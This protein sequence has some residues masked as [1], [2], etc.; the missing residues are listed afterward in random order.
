MTTSSRWI[1]IVAA[2][3]LIISPLAFGQTV[4]EN[5]RSQSHFGPI[6]L[7]AGNF[8]SLRQ[9]FKQLNEDAK[10]TED[11]EQQAKKIADLLKDSKNPQS[12]E[13]MKELAKDPIF[14]DQRFQ[15]WLQ[16]E[17]N[18]HKGEIPPEQF[19]KLDETVK[20][21]GGSSA[22]PTGGPSD[23]E[24]QNRN[25]DDDFEKHLA[26]RKANGGQDAGQPFMGPRPGTPPSSSSDQPNPEESVRRW[27]VDNF[28]PNKGPL[29][30]SPAFQ[31]ALRELRRAPLNLEPPA[32]DQAGWAGKFARWSEDVTKGL[33]KSEFLP[34]FEGSSLKKWRLPSMKSLPKIQSP[35][36]APSFGP[37]PNVALPSATT[38]SRA[39]QVLWIALIAAAGI[40]VWKLLGGNIPGVGRLR[41]A[42]WRLGPWPVSPEA[43]ASRQDV[44]RAFE[45]LSLLKL[46]PS[47]KSRNHLELAAELGHSA[48]DTRQAANRLASVYEK[49][50]YTR[51]DEPLSADA[52]AAARKEL[53]FLAGAKLS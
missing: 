42:G 4:D 5:K 36:S 27:L 43:V 22:N 21:L 8:Q 45:Y 48:S 50:R 18:S 41:K 15:E 29:A 16:G 44:V 30:D 24:L 3:W 1:W 2:A 13:K 17:L 37:A 25:K 47:A 9:R 53:S 51:A 28:N 7:Q 19:K 6:P 26:E 52:I 32:A 34:K 12:L 20:K 10:D 49:A 11:F 40:L 31:D 33:A 35:I 39:L 14:K 38:L 23:P 46:G